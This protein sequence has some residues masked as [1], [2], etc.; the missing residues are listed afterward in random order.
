M[1]RHRHRAA[2]VAATRL[3][4]QR[5]VAGGD[6]GALRSG[7]VGRPGH[8][9][10]GAAGAGGAPSVHCGQTRQGGTAAHLRA[11]LLRRRAERPARRQTGPRPRVHR[12]RR[13]RAVRDAR[14]HASTFPWRQ[15]DRGDA[16]TRVLRSDHSERVELAASALARR[17]AAAG[18][19]G[20]PA[21]RRL[22]HDDRLGYRLAGRRQSHGVGLDLRGGDP[23]R[24]PH[25]HL[26]PGHPTRP[27]ERDADGTAA[28]ADRGRRDGSPRCRSPRCRT[29]H[30]WPIWAAPWPVGPG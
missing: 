4:R 9:R 30:M 26:A 25:T 21:P 3:R 14:R 18:P 29:G 15:R 22:P 28:R 8:R 17:A 23:R 7:A 2:G 20:H 12:L 11:G 10:R 27:S 16:G 1:A 13:D 24:A 6:H 19:V 5:L